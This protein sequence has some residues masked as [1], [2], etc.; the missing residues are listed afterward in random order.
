M[1]TQTRKQVLD[2]M[3]DRIMQ[4]ILHE[5]PGSLDS[6][7]DAEG[8]IW[9]CVVSVENGR[10]FVYFYTSQCFFPFA[11]GHMTRTGKPRIK[12]N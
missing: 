8:S 7:E 6:L 4:G 2:W 3:Y 11:T 10:K 5:E 9:D 12:W 1:K